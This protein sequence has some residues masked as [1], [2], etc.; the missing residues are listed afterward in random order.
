MVCYQFD[1]VSQK[2]LKNLLPKEEKKVID[3][4]GNLGYNPVNVGGGKPLS[5]VVESMAASVGF[6]GVP[7]GM[8][9]VANSVGVPNIVIFT[10]KMLLNYKFHNYINRMYGNKPNMVFYHTIEPLLRHKTL[11]RDFN[12]NKRKLISLKTVPVT[13][14]PLFL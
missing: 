12:F 3:H 9:H 7:S 6:I 14:H 1:G 5:Y 11:F 13:P 8:A 2:E 10:E 4:L